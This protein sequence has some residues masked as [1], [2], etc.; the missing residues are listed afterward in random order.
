MN[1]R[2]TRREL[3]KLSGI[4]ALA[5]LA[6]LA[7]YGCGGVG[8]STGSPIPTA[9]VKLS[10]IDHVVHPDP[11]EPFFRSLLRRYRGVRGFYQK[12]CMR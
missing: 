6:S 11:G 5:E 1:F 10:D 2:V 12:C 9:C 8:T 7:L 4:A 3:L